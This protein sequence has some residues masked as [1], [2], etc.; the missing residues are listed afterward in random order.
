M[1]NKWMPE[2]YYEETHEGPTSGLPF[3]KVPEDHSMPGCLFMCEVRDVSGDDDVEKEIAVHSYANM[4]LLKEKLSGSHY[5]IVRQTLGLLP[6]N[7][8]VRSGAEINDKI[9]KNINVN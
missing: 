5:D 3:I 9:N 4:T 6:L 2:I 7:E 8:A 1:N